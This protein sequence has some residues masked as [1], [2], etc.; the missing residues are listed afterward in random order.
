MA[1]E[2]TRQ[3]YLDAVVEHMVSQ[4]RTDLPLVALAEAAGTSDRMLVYY[5]KTREALLTEV[6]HTV[7]SRRRK[8]L[9]ARLASLPRAADHVS[10]V[11]DVLRWM[12]SPPD[13]AGVRFF[14]AAG[15]LGFG[16]EEPYAGFLRGTI[17]DTVDEATL[18]A[19]RMGADPVFAADFATMFGALGTALACD[20]LATGDV[21]RVSNA[22]D[23]AAGSMIQSLRLS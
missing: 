16:S 5:F 18:T 2:T 6:L 12:A 4:G 15:G 21:D 8:E 22:V 13:N 11:A 19:R 10:A 20:V 3:R 17:E 14:L 9:A 1:G 7:R 23:A